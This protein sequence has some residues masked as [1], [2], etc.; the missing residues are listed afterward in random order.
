MWAIPS[1]L[2]NERSHAPKNAGV[3]E[4]PNEATATPT[5]R[6]ASHHSFWQSM[7]VRAHRALLRG[8][9]FRVSVWV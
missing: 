7:R 8:A 6:I 9:S 1:P 4:A 3:S 5:P 2:Y